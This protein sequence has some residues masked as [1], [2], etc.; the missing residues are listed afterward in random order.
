MMQENNYDSFQKIWFDREKEFIG[1]I[2]FHPE[3]VG[4]VKKII[5]PNYPA[6]GKISDEEYYGRY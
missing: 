4:L 5:V 6:C 2:G 1:G 3:N